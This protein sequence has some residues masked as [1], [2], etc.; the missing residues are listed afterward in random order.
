MKLFITN[1]SKLEKYFD[2]LDERYFNSK[3]IHQIA[4]NML[5]ESLSEGNIP[6]VL[7]PGYSNIFDGVCVLDFKGFKDDIYF[8]EFNA[9]AS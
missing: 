6:V 7:L 9:T 4:Y 3:K 2:S 5:R 8:Y 1:K